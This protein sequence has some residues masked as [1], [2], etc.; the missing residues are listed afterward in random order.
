MT[1]RIC[2]FISSLREQ[3]KTPFEKSHSPL[4]Y[5]LTCG[6]SVFNKLSLTEETFPGH[7]ENNTHAA[8]NGGLT[9]THPSRMRPASGGSRWHEI[10][11]RVEL[12]TLPLPLSLSS[13]GI[14]NCI[15]SKHCHRSLINSLLCALKK[16]HLWGWWAEEDKITLTKAEQTSL[17]ISMGKKIQPICCWRDEIWFRRGQKTVCL[18]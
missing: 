14:V 8:L 3:S 2:P 6:S 17:I 12:Q 9:P 4:L 18:I 15:Q 1:V 13:C 11:C 7:S 5:S 16:V 10:Y